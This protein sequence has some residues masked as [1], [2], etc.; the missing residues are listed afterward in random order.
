MSST[1]V[2]RRSSYHKKRGRVAYL[3]IL[4]WMIGFVVFQIYPFLSSL[5][6]SFT[7]YNILEP[8]KFIGLTNYINLFT[9]D[10]TFY[11]SLGVTLKYI[12]ISLPLKLGS[13]LIIA[14][15]LNQKVRGINF[16]R[17]LYYLPSILGGSIAISALWR[18][19]FMREGLVNA[20]LAKIGV[21]AIDWLGNPDIAL[22]TISLLNVWQFG[23]SMVLFLA[24][25][26]QIPSELYEAA[27][28]DGA[29]KFAMFRKIT[30]P[31]LTP[32]IFFNL[33][34]QTITM[35]QQYTESMVITN[36]GPLKAT[37]VYGLM[38][39][40]NAFQYYKM[41]YASAQSWILFL[42]I[43]VLTALIFK[44]S[45]FWVFYSDGGK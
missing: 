27:R 31:M 5:V 29:G 38:L 42:I 15:L 36:G 30:L 14:L 1:A 23:S 33:I 10:P 37:Y 26:Q 45:S 43:L 17:T 6:F 7:R 35:F 32:I 39:Y 2:R 9:N 12:L 22:T 44:S 8:P 19:L 21:A 24:G 16:Y 4:P 25:L 18:F 41:G 3:Y 11:T 34:M 40:Q 28:V 20:M 13:A